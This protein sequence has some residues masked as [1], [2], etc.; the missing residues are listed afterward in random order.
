MP[1]SA[2][3]LAPSMYS[4][5][6]FL[7]RI[8]ATRTML[9]S[10]TPS[11][12]GLVTISAATSLSHQLFQG[13]EIDAAGF[14]GL[15]VLHRVTGDGRG[16]GI[17]AVGGIRNQNLLARIAALFQQRADQQ[18]AGEFA[19]RAGR[20]LERD[21]VHAADLGQGRFQASAMIVHAALRQRFGL[22]RMRPGEA[23]G[24]C[25]EFVDPRVVLHGAGT[26]RIHAVIDGV[27]P[28]GQAR[29]MA[30]RLHLADFGE[31]FD[32]AAHV[33]GAERFDGIHR[34]DIELG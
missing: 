1:T 31:A 29:E 6:P 7:C 17:G 20:G 18:D 15:D 8:S 16:R 26:Q 4:M 10:N 23:F 30:D 11:V 2:F 28:G 34:G 27:V 25:H 24:T 21:R 32:F 12:F 33:F 22:V 19:V 3:M 14:A 9:F 13:A 5:A